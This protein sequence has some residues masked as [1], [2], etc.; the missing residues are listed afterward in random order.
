MAQ[1]KSAKFTELQTISAPTHDPQHYTSASKVAKVLSN[2]A[3]RA[4]SKSPYP[5]L[6]LRCSSNTPSASNFPNEAKQRQ[7]LDLPKPKTRPSKLTPQPPI[8]V[9]PSSSNI[10]QPVTHPATQT[11]VN[12]NFG[13]NV[14]FNLHPK[15]TPYPNPNGAPLSSYCLNPSNFTDF[16]KPDPPDSSDPDPLT[17]PEVE[18]ALARERKLRLRFKRRGKKQSIPWANV[19]AVLVVV[20]VVLVGVVHVWAKTE[21]QGAYAH[22]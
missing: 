20:A 12:S 18:R 21:V 22:V 10:T 17:D 15:T 2:R 3:L 4:P 7:H 1:N 14:K 6:N 11:N 9:Q 8:T 5:D 13:S 19:G 16:S